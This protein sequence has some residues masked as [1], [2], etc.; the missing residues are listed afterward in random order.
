MK[1][2][3]LWKKARPLFER[4]SQ[5]KDIVRIDSKLAEVDSAV[6][7]EYEEQLQQLSDLHVPVSVPE[8]A[9]LSEEEDEEEDKLAQKGDLIDKGR[10]GVSD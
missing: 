3:E 9:Y 4:S 6:L 10:Q 1:A 8:E 5:M 2:V 7:V